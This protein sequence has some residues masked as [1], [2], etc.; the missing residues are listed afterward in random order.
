MIITGTRILVPW[1]WLQSL[2]LEGCMFYPFWQPALLT[3][4]KIWKLSW[5]ISGLCI[6]NSNKN[7]TDQ[8]FDLISLYK[9][10]V[11]LKT[12][13]QFL[14]QK[15]VPFFL[16]GSK[17]EEIPCTVFLFLCRKINSNKVTHLFLKTLAITFWS[18]EGS[19]SVLQ[20]RTIVLWLHFKIV[21]NI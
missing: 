14:H 7:M 16:D 12:D 13:I 10:H 11:F 3:V 20:E 2:S 4:L 15:T 18:A 21:L 1:P 19:R 17:P 8:N 5:F 6:I 9:I